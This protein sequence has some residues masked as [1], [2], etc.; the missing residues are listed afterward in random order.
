MRHLWAPWRIGYIKGEKTP[1]CILCD[2]PREKKDRAN[3]ILAR[4]K[5]AFVMM[6]LYPYNNG[7]LMVSPYQHVSSLEELS[8]AAT[9]DLIRLMKRALSVLRKTH[10]PDGFNVGLNLGKAAGAGIE[11]HLHFH[12][13]PR[14]S[15]DTNFMTVNAEVRVLPESLA[16]S[17]RQLK[18]YFSRAQR[19]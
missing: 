15:G 7:H 17:Y 12:I 5:H 6:N 13:V 8:D 18:P 19:R 1:G 16:E 4:G 2:K 11:E 9:A 14:W 3:L 10:K